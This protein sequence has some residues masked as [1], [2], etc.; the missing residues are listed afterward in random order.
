MQPDAAWSSAM[1]A[2][3]SYALVFLLA[4]SVAHADSI[5]DTIYNPNVSFPSYGDIESLKFLEPDYGFREQLHLDQSW[6]RFFLENS[7]PRQEPESG[8]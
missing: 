6:M 2:K 4:A 8:D 3:L 5:P 7:G 1:I